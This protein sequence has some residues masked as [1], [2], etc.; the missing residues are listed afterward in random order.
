[1]KYLFGDALYKYSWDQVVAAFWQR[2]PNPK[3]KHVLS[4]DVLDRK[5]VGKKMFSKRLICKTNS[6]PK[7]GERIMSGISRNVY[8]IEESI[9]DLKTNTFTTYTRNIG[10][11]KL[12]SVDEKCV[13]TRHPENTSWVSCL[14]EAWVNSQ[15]TG[16]SSVVSSFGLQRFKKNASSAVTGFDHVLHRLYGTDDS[17][18]L[19]EPMSKKDKLKESAKKAKESAMKATDLAREKAKRKVP[20]VHASNS[21]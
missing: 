8:V 3:S 18:I 11:Q 6:V 17:E 19:H 2:Y 15:I 21:D 4:E 10:L 20:V 9:L 14:R 1:M 16:F 13:Y 7:W 5:V 12:M